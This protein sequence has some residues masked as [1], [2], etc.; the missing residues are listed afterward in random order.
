[1]AA[2]KYVMKSSSLDSMF[3]VVDSQALAAANPCRTC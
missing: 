2:E 3:V 1:M